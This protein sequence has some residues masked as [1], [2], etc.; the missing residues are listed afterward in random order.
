MYMHIEVNVCHSF[1]SCAES[2]PEFQGLRNESKRSFY[3]NV[4]N[5]AGPLSY[6][7]NAK[8]M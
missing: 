5:N 6:F 3:N 1:F 2:F 7:Y 4:I 8:I